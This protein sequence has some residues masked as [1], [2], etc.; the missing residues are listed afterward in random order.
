MSDLEVENTTI[1]ARMSDS[2]IQE[3]KEKTREHHMRGTNITI[4]MYVS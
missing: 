4:L 3:K 2:V 1:M